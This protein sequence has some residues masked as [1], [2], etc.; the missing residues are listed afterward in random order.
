MMLIWLK[1][2][3]IKFNVN[4]KD[5][6]MSNETNNAYI[7]KI[8]NFF[9]RS[10]TEH[11]LVVQKEGDTF[12]YSKEYYPKTFTATEQDSIN[13]MIDCLKLDLKNDKAHFRYIHSSFNRSCTNMSYT[14]TELLD[15]FYDSSVDANTMKK[16]IQLIDNKSFY[17]LAI[18]SKLLASMRK[19]QPH[20]MDNVVNF[21]N[22]PTYFADSSD[23]IR[24]LA[25]SYHQYSD[26][27]FKNYMHIV[28]RA[29]DKLPE[30]SGDIIDS[31][32]NTLVHSPLLPKKEA[33]KGCSKILKSGPALENLL[34]KYGFLD[35]TELFESHATTF[36]SFLVNENSFEFFHKGQD[37]QRIRILNEFVQKQ[38]LNFPKIFYLQTENS[39]YVMGVENKGNHPIEKAQAIIA[40]FFQHSQDDSMSM[41]DMILKVNME[42]DNVKQ[43]ETIKKVKNKI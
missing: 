31:L 42:W 10:N 6:I 1:K 18:A 15:Y 11:C 27:Q 3:R 5:K 32:M 20:T 26:M 37:I 19:R 41:E 16:A 9:T 17:L 14:S 29:L 24:T 23:D 25:D 30:R 7:D 13:E 33:I 36:L 43:D 35:K 2:Q 40:L 28:W 4:L 22:F 21:L 34:A 38:N 12:Y 39:F 8:M